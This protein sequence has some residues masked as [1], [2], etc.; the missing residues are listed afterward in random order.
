VNIRG[1]YWQ[2]AR[3]NYIMLSFI[4]VLFTKYYSNNQIREDEDS[5]E[6]STHETEETGIL[7]FDRKNRK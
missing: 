7:I 2:E 5:G 4:F 1:T 3:E 6:C